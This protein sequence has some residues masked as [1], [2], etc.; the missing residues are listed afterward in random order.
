MD[1]ILTASQNFRSAKAQ[2]LAI[3]AEYRRLS[4][5]DAARAVEAAIVR[6]DL[7]RLALRQATRNPAPLNGVAR[8]RRTSPP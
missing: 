2:L 6:F 1:E 5:E 7:A 8:E 3:E 4:S